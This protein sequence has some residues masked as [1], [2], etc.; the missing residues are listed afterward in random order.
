[1]DVFKR[2]V[3]NEA[4]LQR[5][6]VRRDRAAVRALLDTDFVEV[7]RT[8]RA[9]DAE[10]VIEAL[11]GQVGYVQ[12]PMSDVESATI[13]PGVELLTYRDDTTWHSSLWVRNGSGDWLLRYHQQTSIT[14]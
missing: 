12:P 2:I 7:D 10:G 3:E 4:A 9:W 1:M 13:A 11:A 6:E 14:A 8:G 5:P